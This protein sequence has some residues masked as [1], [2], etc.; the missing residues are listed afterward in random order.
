MLPLSVHEILGPFQA[1]QRASH[2]PVQDLDW[3]DT[4]HAKWAGGG[5]IGSVPTEFP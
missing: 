4:S 3:K 5:K 1:H 2:A